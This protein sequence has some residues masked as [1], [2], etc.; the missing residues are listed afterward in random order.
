MT[1]LL[2]T[3]DVARLL[4]VNRHTVRIWARYAYRCFPPHDFKVKHWF[5]WKK[6]TILHWKYKYLAGLSK[7][8]TRG[9]LDLKSVYHSL[10][11]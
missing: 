6:S 7:A 2:S 5:F 9:P 11:W 10:P 8:K 4:N 1:D 3:K